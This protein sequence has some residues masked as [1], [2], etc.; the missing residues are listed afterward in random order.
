MSNLTLPPNFRAPE[1]HASSLS[2]AE[3]M[4]GRNLVEEDDDIEDD[5]GMDDSAE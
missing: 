3:D 2:S 1:M 4:G 5:V